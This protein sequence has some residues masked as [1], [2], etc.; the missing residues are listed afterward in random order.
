MQKKKMFLALALVGFAF[1]ASAVDL[2]NV[3]DNVVPATNQ[4]YATGATAQ[5][6]G[7]ASSLAAI[8]ASADTG[9]GAKPAFHTFTDG[10]TPSIGKGW[11]CEGSATQTYTLLPGVTGP[12]IFQKNEGGSRDALVVRTNSLLN[13]LDV[14]NCTRVQTSADGAAQVTYSGTCSASLIGKPSHLGFTDVKSTVFAAKSLL[15]ASTYTPVTNTA[16][17]DIA[18]GGGQGF[19]VAVSPALFALLQAEQGLTGDA[20]PNIT[21]SQYATVMSS[22]TKA[23]TALLPSG[24]SHDAT[25]LIV[26]RRSTSSGTQ[27]AA[28]IFFLGNPCSAGT[29]ATGVVGSLNATAGNTTG[30]GIAG[31]FGSGQN[32]LRVIQ[33]GTTEGVTGYLSSAT[34]YA[35]GV[36]SLENAQPAT[37]WKYLKI[38]GV[39]PGTANSPEYQKKNILNGTYPFAFEMFIQQNQNASFGNATTA[40]TLANNIN[41]FKTALVNFLN[42]GS[43][44]ATMNGIYGDPTAPGAE[45][46]V[47]ATNTSRYTRTQRDCATPTLNW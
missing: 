2:I 1:D 18:T 13:Q 24:R 41:D 14:T 39:H 25:P 20:V 27:A 47:S 8:C 7:I 43:N 34:D 9:A 11:K 6:T 15:T 44:T 23:W 33:N 4:I 5:T 45:K 40:G 12:W 28:E 32:Q 19:G 21:K 30:T 42:A 31:A 37:G 3:T 16:L 17:Y 36:I 38:D 22:T 26:A 10:A 29:G 35:I 46:T